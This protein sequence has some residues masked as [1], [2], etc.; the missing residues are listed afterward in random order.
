MS[1]ASLPRPSVLPGLVEARAGV[2]SAQAVPLGLV[3]EPELGAA[4]E[5]ASALLAQ[6]ESLRLAVLAEADRRRVADRTADTGTDAWAAALTGDRREAMRGGLLLAQDLRE[7]F[8]HVREAFAA[9]RL[10]LPQVRIVVNALRQVP[11]EATPEQRDLAEEHLVARAT[12]VASR[13]GRP[14]SLRRL[15]VVSR[16]MFDPIDRDLADAHEAAMLRR[17]KRGADAECFLSL[18]DNGDGSFSGRFRVPELHGRLL[19]GALQRLTAPRRWG[20]DRAGA[21]VVDQTVD[22][23]NVHEQHGAAFCELLEHLPTEGWSANGT[24]LLVTIELQHLLDGLVGAGRLDTG[25]R[26]SAGEARR[27]ACEA[28]IVPVVLGGASVPLDLGRTRRLHSG[29][30]RAAL[31]TVHETCAATGCERP[32]AWTE[33]HHWVPWSRGGRTDL[34]D[35]VPLCGHHHRQVHDDHWRVERHA[36]GSV[37]FHRRR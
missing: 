30:Q 9:G 37:R 3:A 31:A 5:E 8:H 13:T 35:A 12:G 16:R 32:F 19:L 14:L 28:G 33:V 7:R 17:E 29:A 2:A 27:L 11:E 1:V 36:D 10:T 34:R 23:H 21:P 15:R 20:R 18:H 22:V 4:L 6:A 25:A 24:T 26:I